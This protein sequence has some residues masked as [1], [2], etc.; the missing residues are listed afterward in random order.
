MVNTGGVMWYRLIR[1]MEKINRLR[2]MSNCANM[3]KRVKAAKYWNNLEI[4]A[5]GKF[6]DQ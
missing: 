1:S 5:L 6:H 4:I 2:L 3:M